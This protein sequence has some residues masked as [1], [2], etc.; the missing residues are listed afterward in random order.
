MT[1]L[2]LRRPTRRH[3]L[4]TA[5]LT[6]LGVVAPGCDA[7]TAT[8]ALP[9]NFEV[10]VCN[11]LAHGR[12][13]AQGTLDDMA[14]LG[15]NSFR[16]DVFWNQVETRKNELVWP[17]RFAELDSA[18]NLA[19]ARGQR[20]LLVLAY[21]NSLHFSGRYP[22]D[23]ASQA[24]FVRYAEFVARHFKGRV[25][26]LEVWN[27]WNQ[28]GDARDY[29]RLISKVYPALKRIDPNVIVVGGAVEGAGK[30]DF[31]ATL[32]R[33]G[34]LQSMDMLSVHPYVFW[35]GD[36]GT[37]QALMRWLDDL[38]TMLA[39]Y[40][41]GR[42]MPLLL[43]EIGWPS[44]GKL[45]VPPARAAD[46]LSQ[47]LLSLRSRADVHGV[48]WYNLY[49]KGRDPNDHEVNFGLF[50]EDYQRKPAVAAFASVAHVVQQARAVE[51]LPTP[52][53]VWALRFEMGG[54]RDDVLALWSSDAQP[55]RWHA[56]MSG[57]PVQLRSARQATAAPTAAG[58]AG[59]RLDAT[60]LLVDTPASQRASLQLQVAPVT[61]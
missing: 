44:A 36:S 37:P 57:A 40:R 14:T 48:W 27:E 4:K 46:Y 60:P 10:G 41:Q 5:A 42:A 17:Q 50:T 31:I 26:Y 47:T 13:T 24:A 6:S 38:Q 45:S 53:S 55:G 21:E 28:H 51:R 1:L 29:A 56:A 20:P 9:A 52:A 19:L 8:A 15:A 30:P 16:D 23:D 32:A 33:E 58:R 43:T 3:L 11:H 34:A 35:R 59:W 54:R 7:Q 12:G 39:P 18:V 22:I 25:R 2:P 49:D 61:G